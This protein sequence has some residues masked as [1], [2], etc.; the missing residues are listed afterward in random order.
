MPVTERLSTTTIDTP[1]LRMSVSAS[2]M[3]NLT[4]P[5]SP[6]VNSVRAAMYKKSPGKSPLREMIKSRCHDR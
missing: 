2:H 6:R 3:S 4:A 5:K 1:P